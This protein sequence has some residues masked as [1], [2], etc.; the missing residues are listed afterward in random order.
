M[1]SLKL[2]IA[3]AVIVL[4]SSFFS[5]NWLIK[6]PEYYREQGRKEERATYKAASDMANIKSW[7]DLVTTQQQLTKERQHHADEIAKHQE[8]FNRYIA[9]VRAGRIAGLRI[10]RTDLCTAGTEKTTSTSGAI[11]ATTVRL[12]REVEEGLFRFAHDRDQ[13]ILDFETFKQEVR[14]AKCFAD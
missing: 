1:T 11:E 8:K 4:L 13:I 5:V 6:L 14:L 12:P 7:R 10:N 3:G 2:R 9:D